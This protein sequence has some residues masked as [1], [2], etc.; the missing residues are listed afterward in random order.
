NIG[1]ERLIFTGTSTSGCVQSAIYDAL[2]LGYDVSVVA[3]A[4]A[5]ATDASQ[6]HALAQLKRARVPLVPASEIIRQVA[7]LPPADRS[8]KS[9]LKRAERY[10][11]TSPYVPNDRA[12]DQVGPYTLIFGPAI[13]L[14]LR[15]A[16]TAL[17]LVDAQQLTCDRASPLAALLAEDAE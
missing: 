14:D 8:R 11:P 5:D 4:C 16:N 12:A 10:I 13:P 6:R 17:V 1:I 9:G 7:P 2:D 3:D 15:R